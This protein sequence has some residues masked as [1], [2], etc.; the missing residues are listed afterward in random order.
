[1]VTQCDVPGLTLVTQGREQCSPVQRPLA[2]V[3]GLLLETRDLENTPK[4][5][6]AK[7]ELVNHEHTTS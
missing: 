3:L 2:L 1:M 6:Q 4:F 5:L 7:G